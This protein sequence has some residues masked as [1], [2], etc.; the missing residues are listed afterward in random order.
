MPGRRGREGGGD[1][2]D[3]LGRF[4]RS[5]ANRDP[6]IASRDRHR[7]TKM[8][9]SRVTRFPLPGR[10]SQPR[11]VLPSATNLSASS[12]LEPIHSLTI[13]M[14]ENSDLAVW[15]T[16]LI[17]LMANVRLP[18]LLPHV[19]EII[20]A[21]CVTCHA[22]GTHDFPPRITPGIDWDL[23]DWERYYLLELLSWIVTDYASSRP[24]LRI[25]VP[26]P[27]I[28]E[29]SASLQGYPSSQAPQPEIFYHPH[30]HIPPRPSNIIYI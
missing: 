16:G 8:T 5:W 21:L 3:C 22:S 10:M 27:A 2:S 14:P 13:T 17:C 6:F 29:L 4:S 24:L 26:I 15:A 1:S 23:Y 7:D 11:R 18:D 20:A 19:S 30:F 12:S 9:L 25:G 28:A